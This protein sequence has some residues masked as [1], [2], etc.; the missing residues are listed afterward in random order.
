MR[1]VIF[2][3]IALFVGIFILIT[4]KKSIQDTPQTE[5]TKSTLSRTEKDNVIQFWAIYKDATNDRINEEWELAADK[6]KQA[7]TLNQKHEDAWYY[8]G[9]MHLELDQHA[10]AEQCWKELISLN[11]KNSRAYMQLA[12][13]YISSKEHFHLD[14]AEK[15]CKESLAINK[16]ETGPVQ[17][18]GEVYLIRGELEQAADLFES[19]VASNFKSIDSYFLRGYIDW[20]KGRK[21]QA[22]EWYTKAIQYAQPSEHVSEK[23]LGEGDTKNGKGFGSVTSKSVFQPLM[24]KLATVPVPQIASEMENH[25]Q[26]L[27]TLL[28]ALKRRIH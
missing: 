22:Q 2:I 7:L 6:Y 24:N 11:P 15:A 26:E 16:E 21:S 19:S 4:W 20:K 8:L 3:A 12:D 28:S 23:V 25:Y 5:A 27:Q 13:L 17:L 9:N 1:K 10:A 14:K 18:L